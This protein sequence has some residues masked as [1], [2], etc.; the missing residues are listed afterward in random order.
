[1]NTWIL[2][3]LLLAAGTVGCVHALSSRRSLFLWLGDSVLEDVLGCE[4]ARKLD[5]AMAS[6]L[7]IFGALVA[8]G[9]LRPDL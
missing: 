3:L 7:A 5:L 9:V 8:A 6:T 2:A 1:M 4:C